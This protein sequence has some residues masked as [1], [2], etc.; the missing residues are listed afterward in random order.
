[1]VVDYEAAWIRL[2]SQIAQKPQHGRDT[3]LRAMAEIA[4]QCQVPGGEL[5]RLL[6]LYSIEVERTRSIHNDPAGR[7]TSDADS[8][9]GGMTGPRDIIDRRGGHDGRRNGASEPTGAR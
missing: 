2:Q 4:E 6:R 7:V 1:V 3:L 9:G 8:L 5:S